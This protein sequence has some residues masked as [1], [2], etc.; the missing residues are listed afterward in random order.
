MSLRTVGRVESDREVRRRD[1]SQPSGTADQ[2]RPQRGGIWRP[3]GPGE[4]AEGQCIET[5][6]GG[7]AL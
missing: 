3:A 5:N 2:G 6:G 7:E 4:Q 1:G